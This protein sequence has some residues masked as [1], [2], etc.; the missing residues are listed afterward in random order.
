[1]PWK[2]IRSPYNA[3]DLTTLHDD[4]MIAIESALRRAAGEPANETNPSWRA[5]QKVIPLAATCT[6]E[7]DPVG[8]LPPE[9]RS[10]PVWSD[11][12]H[13]P[14]GTPPASSAPLYRP[15]RP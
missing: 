15:S 6:G 1:M 12:P 5:W 11:Y 14:P 3:L 7:G 8:I 9:A 10:S 2:I 13:G 4:E